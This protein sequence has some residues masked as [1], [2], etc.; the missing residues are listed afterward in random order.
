[1]ISC[2]IHRQ[3]TAGVVVVN[4]V[5]IFTDNNGSVVSCMRA[6]GKTLLFSIFV[7][8]MWKGQGLPS[9]HWYEWDLFPTLLSHR[10]LLEFSITLEFRFALG[11]STV[12]TWTLVL[13]SNVLLH[14]CTWLCQSLAETQV[15]RVCIYSFIHCYVILKLF[16]LTHRSSH[17][18]VGSESNNLKFDSKSKTAA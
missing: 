17:W 2:G 1:M 5:H 11:R 14:H 12:A 9:L 15:F 6:G 10:S 18:N 16:V 3:S 8:T 13:F 4:L 7:W